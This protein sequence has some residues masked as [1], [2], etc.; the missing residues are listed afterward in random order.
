MTIY[1]YFLTHF[2]PLISFEATFITGNAGN[3]IPWGSCYAVNFA[4]FLDL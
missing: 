2:M 1:K 3:F 4:K